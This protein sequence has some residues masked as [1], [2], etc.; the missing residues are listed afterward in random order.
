MTSETTAAPTDMGLVAFYQP[1]YNLMSGE[2]Q[3][4]EALARRR[5]PGAATLP[6][7]LTEESE[8][9]PEVSPRDIDLFILEDAL[10]RLARWSND[11]GK[12]NLKLSV[13]LSVEF[14]THP[15]MIEDIVSALRRHGVTPDRLLVDLSVAVYRRTTDNTEFPQHVRELQDAGFTTCLDGFTIDDLDVL[16]LALL[17]RVD[18]V[19][20][21]PSQPGMGEDML[22]Y[23][24]ERVHE[25]G[26][27]IVAAGVETAEQLDLVRDLGCAWAQGYLIGEPVEGDEVL[28]APAALS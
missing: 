24:A 25:Q 12:E 7:G 10:G 20:L 3:G 18:I 17:N 15:D 4:V 14:T 21:H 9:A 28:S 27:P 23:V 1:F 16:E 22:R 11:A 6:E 8:T 19:K 5:T 2:M 13:N 26:V